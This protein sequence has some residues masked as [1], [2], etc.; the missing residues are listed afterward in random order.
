MKKEI[1]ATIS[2]DLD[3]LLREWKPPPGVKIQHHEGEM[4]AVFGDDNLAA[5]KELEA[6][7]A[8][9]APTH[10][11]EL[12][13]F[14]R[15]IEFSVED[16]RASELLWVRIPAT[17]GLEVV[18]QKP[19]EEIRCDRCGRKRSVLHALD[20]AYFRAQKKPT[21]PMLA[22]LTL[23][24]VAREV[25][26]SLTR[27]A[28]DVGLRAVPCSITVGPDTLDDA[29]FWLTGTANLGDPAGET[30]L[31]PPCEKCG[32]RPV[33]ENRSF[34]WAFSRERWNGEDFC[35]SSFLG[36][37]TLYVSQRVYQHLEASSASKRSGALFEPIELK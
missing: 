20:R 30:E 4:H 32:Q 9:I 18:G 11:V 14:F 21:Q 27:A 29:Y 16:L 12:D 28:M 6:V 7:I 36:L 3:A 26:E 37:D 22:A 2:G 1:A 15:A 24:L 23:K 5:Y 10:K 19:V 35:T 8:R 17:S 31:G 13:G 33:V 25:L 34:L